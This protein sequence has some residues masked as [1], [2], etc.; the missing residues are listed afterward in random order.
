MA[1]FWRNINLS[2]TSDEG[3][4]IQKNFSKEENA[5]MTTPIISLDECFYMHISV[6]HDLGILIPL[7]LFEPRV[8]ATINVFS[9]QISFNRRCFIREIKINYPWGE[10]TLPW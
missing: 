4:V 9:S 1:S 3:D 8:L 7:T 2:R 10:I 6:V 5:N